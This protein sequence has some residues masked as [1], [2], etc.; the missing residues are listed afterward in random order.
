MVNS[1]FVGELTW[2]SSQAP[3]DWPS[4]AEFNW[5]FPFFWR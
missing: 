5:S 2:K 1:D 4:T 3:G